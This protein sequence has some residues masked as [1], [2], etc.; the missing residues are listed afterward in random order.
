MKQFQVGDPVIYLMTK[1]S[2]HPTLRATQVSPAQHGDNY[3]YVVEKF[4]VVREVLPDGQLQ[5]QTR[6]G[7]TRVIS[8]D[9]PCLKRASWWDRWVHRDRFPQLDPFA[10]PTDTPRPKRTDSARSLST[11][12]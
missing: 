10:P 11:P 7:K 4:W 6:R 12:E 1:Q 5:V 2:S 3:S 8:P 9:D